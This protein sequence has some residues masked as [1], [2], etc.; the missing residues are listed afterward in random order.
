MIETTLAWIYEGVA[1]SSSQAR[2]SR[3]VIGEI[4]LD[5]WIDNPDIPAQLE[6]FRWQLALAAEQ[7]RPATIHCLRAWG[8]L[9][10]VLKSSDQ[11]RR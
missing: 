10:E 8:M 7:D 6:C 3:V 2:Q 1:N 5:R 4:G 11:P 9:E